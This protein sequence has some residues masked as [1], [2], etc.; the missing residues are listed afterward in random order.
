MSKSEKPYMPPITPLILPCS[1]AFLIM[2]FTPECKHPASMHK[3]FLPFKNRDC[4]PTGFPGSLHV[5]KILSEIFTGS[6]T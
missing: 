5:E 2:F 3:P 6:V 4:S 1:F